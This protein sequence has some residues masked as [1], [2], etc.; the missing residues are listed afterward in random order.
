M[1]K[2]NKR[3]PLTLKWLIYVFGLFIVLFVGIVL[4]NKT[5][6]QISNIQWRIQDH[7]VYV[8]YDVSNNKNTDVEVVFLIQLYYHSPIDYYDSN[9]LITQKRIERNLPPN[10]STHIDE[11]FMVNSSKP[12]S[13]VQILVEKSTKI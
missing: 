4:L 8:D 7:I 5:D 11:H 12:I 1:T 6:V 13:K 3:K 2:Y 9:K 10:S